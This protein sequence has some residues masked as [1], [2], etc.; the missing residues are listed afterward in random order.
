MQKS[1][2]CYEC[3][4]IFEQRYRSDRILPVHFFFYIFPQK[5]VR[6]AGLYGNRRRPSAYAW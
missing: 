1:E 3:D 4:M 2:A 6:G 5:H